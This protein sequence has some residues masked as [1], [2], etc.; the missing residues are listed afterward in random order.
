MKIINYPTISLEAGEGGRLD[1]KIQSGYFGG[2]SEQELPANTII[3]L[4]SSEA[5]EDLFEN[6]LA[7]NSQDQSYFELPAGGTIIN[8]TT[9]HT[10]AEEV[11]L[12]GDRPEDGSQVFFNKTQEFLESLIKDTIDLHK[13]DFWA[14]NDLEPQERE[15][16]IEDLKEASR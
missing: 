3:P 10:P 4:Y 9:L 8:P 14:E 13:E 5:T 6:I 15:V 2:T 7:N 1:I 16:T 12:S 11:T